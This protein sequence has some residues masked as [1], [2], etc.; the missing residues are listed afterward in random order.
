ME[1]DEEKGR[2]DNWRRYR[3]LGG[4]GW[5]EIGYGGGGGFWE[6]DLEDV[7]DL[8]QPKTSNLSIQALI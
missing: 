7:N 8:F 6:D 1:K 5:R 3:V 2:G 4:G